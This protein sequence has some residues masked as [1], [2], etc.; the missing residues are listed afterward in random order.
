[1]IERILVAIDDTADSLAA[2]RLAIELATALH[3][4]LRA[5]HVEVDHGLPKVVQ[6]ASG[7]PGAGARLAEAGVAMLHRVS[8]LAAAARLELQT[9]VLTGEIAPAI[10]HDARQWRADLVVLG[11]SSRSASGEPYIGARSRHVLEFADQPVVI[12]PPPEAAAR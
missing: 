9:Q 12:V 11:K 10:L 5:V 8:A 2:A 3:A 4:E 1:M 7:E 6:A